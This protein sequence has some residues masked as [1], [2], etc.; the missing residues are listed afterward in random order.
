MNV[1]NFYSRDVRKEEKMKGLIKAADGLTAVILTLA[2]GTMIGA[3]FLQVFF[4]FVVQ[5]PLYWTEE[6]SRYSF[7][8]VVFIGAAWAGKN[9]MHL[10]V[11]YFT[12]K[13]PDSVMRVLR[14]ILDC[15]ILAFSAVIVAAGV[16]VVPVNLKQSSPALHIPMGAVYVAI[17]IGFGLLFVYYLE[18]LLNDLNTWKQP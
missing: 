15:L 4:R 3:I 7:V 2:A 16:L 11:D 8:Y 12:L 13:L 1:S 6:L 17:P 10:G 18:H 5:S 9:H 14:V